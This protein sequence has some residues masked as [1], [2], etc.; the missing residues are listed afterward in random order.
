[1]YCY[2]LISATP[3]RSTALAWSIPSTSCSRLCKCASTSSGYRLRPTPPTSRLAL[4]RPA[5]WRSIL[6]TS[7]HL[8]M[9]RVACHHRTRGCRTVSRPWVRFSPCTVLGCPRSVTSETVR[10]RGLFQHSLCAVLSR[11]MVRL[12]GLFQQSM[13]SSRC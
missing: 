13:L 10:L 12:R 9:G 5:Q 4:W 2:T 11:E 8:C 7:L 3:A 6:S 1:M